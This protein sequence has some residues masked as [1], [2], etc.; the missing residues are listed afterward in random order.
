M[1]DMSYIRSLVRKLKLVRFVTPI[2]ASFEN[3]SLAKLGSYS[4]RGIGDSALEYECGGTIS[5]LSGLTPAHFELGLS[6]FERPTTLVALTRLKPGDVAW[7]VGANTGFYSL[8]MGALVGDSGRVIGLE[9]NRSVFEQFQRNVSGDAT[10]TP[11]CKG[12]SNRNGTACFVS[13][14]GF[15][16]V[17]CIGAG[18]LNGSD[19]T[20]TTIEIVRGDDLIGA[21]KL[22]QPTFLKIDVEGHELEAIEGLQTVLAHPQ[23][24]A[25][26]VEVHFAMLEEAG[27]AGG[28]A[29]VR[30]MLA[31]CGL[32]RQ[33]WVAR[34]HLLAKRP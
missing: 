12:L 4:V 8:L 33:Q 14:A 11:L 19:A 32:T 34:S 5:R 28:A 3:R 7:D 9:P 24:K 10:V 26:L 6:K 21:S 17:G 22:P 25:V 13:P 30:A 27:H 16:P 15:S 23:C 29:R 18:V 20:V 31:A 2:V 1:A